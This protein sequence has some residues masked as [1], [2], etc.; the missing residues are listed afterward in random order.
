[1]ATRRIKLPHRFMRPAAFAEATGLSPWWIRR[2]IRRGRL[3]LVKFRHHPLIG[4]PAPTT[5]PADDDPETRAR[6]TGS[7]SP[8]NGGNGIVSKF[9]EEV[10]SFGR[11]KPRT[12][13][14]GLHRIS[15]DVVGSRW[16]L[17]KRLRDL[18]RTPLRAAQGTIRSDESL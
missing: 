12:G 15:G 11:T 4:P 6:A 5:P 17:L 2:L 1:M 9:R 18:G 7:D 3:R 14:P 16:A 10:G 13:N 8:G